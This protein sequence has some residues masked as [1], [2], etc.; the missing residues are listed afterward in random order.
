MFLRVPKDCP[1][2]SQK[3]F[4][5]LGAKTS[6]CRIAEQ[7]RR[8]PQALRNG[9]GLDDDASRRGEQVS[10]HRPHPLMLGLRAS[11]HLLF[12]K[13]T[14][15]QFGRAP[16]AA[17]DI[18]K[19]DG[20][21]GAEPCPGRNCLSSLGGEQRVPALR[22]YSKLM[23]AARLPGCVIAWPRRGARG[24]QHALVTRSLREGY[25]LRQRP[26][27]DPHHSALLPMCDAVCAQRRNLGN[28][29]K[30][31]ATNKNFRNEAVD[32]SATRI[33]PRLSQGALDCCYRN[34]SVRLRF[35][36]EPGKT[37][38]RLTY[39]S[40]ERTVGRAKNWREKLHWPARKAAID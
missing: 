35:S 22:L 4:Q 6:R 40:A 29:T 26:F 11:F 12:G 19:G 9:R 30:V 8:A 15:I 21:S 16:L 37:D 20:S 31:S 10:R 38:V 23:L 18:D 1:N 14:Q 28:K 3:C 32:R 13:Q 27:R 17:S 39:W 2:L 25:L 24:R 5:A 7:F 34:I 33:V 36:L